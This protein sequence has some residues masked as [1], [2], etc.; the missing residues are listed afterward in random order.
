MFHLICPGGE[1]IRVGGVV[2]LVENQLWDPSTRGARAICELNNS[3]YEA[4]SR[5]RQCRAPLICG[6]KSRKGPAS[7]ESA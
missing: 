4:V 3:V 7:S 6:S 1:E 2:R 5:Q